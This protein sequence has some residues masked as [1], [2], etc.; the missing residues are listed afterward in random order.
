MENIR[1]SAISKLNRYRKSNYRKDEKIRI[2]E[3][4]YQNIRYVKYKIIDVI[5]KGLYNMYVCKNKNEI[6]TTFTDKD[7]LQRYDN[8][9]Y[10]LRGW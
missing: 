1:G 9:K 2:L 5:D 7:I 8:K 3:H 4:S 10:I 6:R